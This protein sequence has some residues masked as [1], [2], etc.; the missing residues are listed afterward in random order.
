L[1]ADAV[2]AVLELLAALCMA[3]A[4][5]DFLGEVLEHGAPS[6]AEI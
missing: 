1:I 5:A 4:L 6:K 3:K 2:R